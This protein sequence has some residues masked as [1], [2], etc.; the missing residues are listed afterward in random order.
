MAFNPLKKVTERRY[1][2]EFQEQFQERLRSLADLPAGTSTPYLTVSLDWRPSGSD[3]EYR[4]AIQQFDHHANRLRQEHWPRGETFDSLSADID[5]IRAWFENEADPAARGVFIVANSGAGV[6]QAIPLGLP[7][8]DRV[9]AG[10]TP[11]LMSLARLDED[12]PTYAV[13]LADQQKARLSMVNQAHRVEGLHMKSSDYP[14]K[15]QTGGWSQRRFQQRADERIL[16]LA[17]QIAEE[18]EQYLIERDIDTLIIA[19]DEIITGAL[20]R[21]MSG[22]LAGRVAARIRLDIEATGAEIL[23]ATLPI[24]AKAEADRE[25]SAVV[26]AS[27]LVGGGHRAASGSAEVIE[28]LASGRV[29]ELIINEDF[30]EDG[31]AD[32]EHGRYGV[33]ENRDVFTGGAEPVVASPI[34]VEEEMVRLAIRTGAEIDVIHAGVPVPLDADAPTPD[35]GS[36]PRSPAAERLDKLGGV[37]AI[38]RY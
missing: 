20:D 14:R 26:A 35:A 37:A 5:R 15:Q 17:R 1:D 31:W 32:F 18:T 36:I 24:A 38:L 7:L 30:H 8:R 2:T 28:A 21:V 13:L 4:G 12:N 6:F 27:D 3:P 25:L 34:D 9:S 29:R 33:G 19:G 23:D 10:P 22:E 11:A 16:A